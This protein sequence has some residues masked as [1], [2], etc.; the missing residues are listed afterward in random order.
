MF[1]NPTSIALFATIRS[2]GALPGLLYAYSIFPSGQISVDPIVT[3]LPSVPLIFA[4]NFLDNNPSNLFVLNLHQSSPGAAFLNIDYT[5]LKASVE[6]IITISEQ[7]TSCWAAY[8]PH[9]DAVYI[10]D[11]ARP[12][13]TTISTETGEVSGQ[14][15]FSENKV[16][17]NDGSNARVDRKRRYILS[18]DQVDPK[19]I[20]MIVGP[21][22]VRTTI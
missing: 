17:K 22:Q 20:V 16:V 11:A 19:V 18:D 2:N 14:T 15:S 1:F 13:V 6:N 8:A 12:N 10:I 3:P 9:F 21:G 7:T 4:L 5:R